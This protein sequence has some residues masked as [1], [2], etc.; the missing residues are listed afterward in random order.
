MKLLIVHNFYTHL[1]GEDL[2]VKETSEL[3]K[4]SREVEVVEYYKYSQDFREFSLLKKITALLKG[5][6]PFY[7]PKDFRELLKREKPDLVQVHNFIPLINIW[8][9]K[10]IRKSRIPVLY[11]IHNYR[12]SCPRGSCFLSSRSHAKCFDRPLLFCVMNNC[13]GGLLYSALYAYRVFLQRLFSGYP[14]GFL[15]RSRFT[16]EFYKKTLPGKNIV[17]I[18]WHVDIP[19]G[20]K[21]ARKEKGDFVVFA[22]RLVKEKGL[23]TV[24]QAAAL[25]KDIKFKIC[26]E[27]PM[28][29]YSRRF[30]RRNGLTNVELLGLV[31][32]GELLRIIRASRV[33][34]FSSCWNEVS[35]RSLLE[36]M[37]LGV[38]VVAADF[39]V[40][41]EIVKDGV[42]GLLY[43][44]NNPADLAE[45]VR[46]LFRDAD[47]WEKISRNAAQVNSQNAPADYLRSLLSAYGSFLR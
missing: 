2:S 11:F 4:N 20:L 43:E 18:K 47:L 44:V 3:L 21:Q 14:D 34:I 7:V 15:S 41:P 39:G 36:A 12:M 28:G 25:L 27:G 46:R 45:K 29:N 32:H 33:L 42:N 8:I 22:G 16:S 30:V 10:E 19:A 17:D 13:L 38:A 6:F 1:T 37:G 35:P 31:E 40:T 5:N 9:L 26:G 23:F 24:L